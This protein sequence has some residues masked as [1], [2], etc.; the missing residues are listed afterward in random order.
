M[1]PLK[2]LPF[3]ALSLGVFIV[4]FFAGREPQH[5]SPTEAPP[6]EAPQVVASSPSAAEQ[7]TLIGHYESKCEGTCYQ[8]V[9]DCI[10]S[11]NPPPKMAPPPEFVEVCVQS[12]ENTPSVFSACLRRDG[13]CAGLLF[14]MKGEP[15]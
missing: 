1:K 5:A 7:P 15:F 11:G 13:F 14:C 9:S 6:A 12:C 10:S 4:G 8:I 3:L 2:P